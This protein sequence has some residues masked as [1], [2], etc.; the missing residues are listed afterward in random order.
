M[1]TNYYLHEKEPVTCEH[2]GHTEK[3]EPLH[4]GKSSGGW[5]FSLHVIPDEGLNSLEDWEARWSRPGA[6]IKDEY[7]DA[8][9]PEDMR[10]TITERS[11]ASFSDWTNSA[12][13]R[14]NAEHG[15]QNLMRHR[16]GG[17]CI[18]HGPGT[19]DYITGEFF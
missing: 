16:L 4:I 5:C 2:C 11:R 13:A 1:G 17:S 15:P 10:A 19:W 7:G 3:T 18:G 9:T 12:L 8:Q 14:N 6:F